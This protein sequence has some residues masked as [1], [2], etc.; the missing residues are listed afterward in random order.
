MLQP[1]DN[2]IK[3]LLNA[4]LSE[5][6]EHFSADALTYYGA[7]V[8]GLE[9][10]FRQVVEELAVDQRRDKLVIILTTL[11]GNAE[12]VE[13]FVNLVR[14]FYATVDFII[15]DYAYGAGTIF[16]MSG[17]NIYMDYYSVLGPIDPQVQN[18]EG[19]LVP[20]LGYLD[21]I[22]EL[23][24]K[25]RRGVLT[26]AEFAILQMMDLAE[27]KNYEQAK[28]LTIDLLKQW[29]VKYKF[30]NW[31]VHKTDSHKKGNPVTLNEKERRAE[32]IASALSDNK[33]WKSHG[34]PIP[35]SVLR[36]LKLEIND[37]SK[38]EKKKTLIQGYYDLLID[39]INKNNYPFFIH[40]RR[41]I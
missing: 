29:L 37:Y 5:I 4:K 26:N 10:W 35:L 36:D 17:D 1:V 12:T 20:A 25:D 2:T 8:T 15:P 39:F 6:E 31:T 41:F 9:Q 32:E 30:K 33:K 19:R 40:T 3:D 28:A 11:G 38:D 23:I 22:E 24:E 16:C 14:E 21:K 13:R 34:R 7:L 18:K 27:M